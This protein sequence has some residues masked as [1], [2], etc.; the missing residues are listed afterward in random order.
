MITKWKMEMKT[1]NELERTFS[2]AYEYANVDHAKVANVAEALHKYLCE[3]AHQDYVD[4]NIVLEWGQEGSVTVYSVFC[5]RTVL[6][7][8][9]VTA[10]VCTALFQV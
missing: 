10:G 5:C 9:T 7:D 3:N 4:S 2:F 1:M 6:P 8:F